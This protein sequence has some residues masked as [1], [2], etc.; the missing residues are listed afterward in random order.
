MKFEGKKKTE[1]KGKEKGK[2]KQPVRR[3]GEL[4]STCPLS[5]PLG[6]KRESYLLRTQE[7]G[8]FI[9]CDRVFS[10]KVTETGTFF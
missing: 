8:W 1:E 2:E 10:L 3:G 4:G 9:L 6:C 5:F 7:A